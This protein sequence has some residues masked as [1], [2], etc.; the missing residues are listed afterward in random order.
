MRPACACFAPLV[1]QREDVAGLGLCAS[2]PGFCDELELTVLQ[3]RERAHVPAAVHDDL[4]ALERRVEVRDDAYAP[5]TLCGKDERLRG[6]HVLVPGAERAR[7]EL[8]LGRR[9]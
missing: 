6:R 7:L 2:T 9:L 4:L 8:F 1:H 5:F 3:V